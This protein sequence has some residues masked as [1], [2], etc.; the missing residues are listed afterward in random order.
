M[1]ITS[2][3][4]KTK[5][6][7]FWQQLLFFLSTSP[8]FGRLEWKFEPSMPSILRGEL[9]HEQSVKTFTN[10]FSDQDDENAI[11][12][13]LIKTIFRIPTN[14]QRPNP[15][16]IGTGNE[17]YTRTPEIDPQYNRYHINQQT[18]SNLLTDSQIQPEDIKM[19]QNKLR[20]LITPHVTEQVKEIRDFYR[21]KLKRVKEQ[22]SHWN[23]LIRTRN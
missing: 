23:Q 9:S 18:A 20:V 5:D 8:Y 7:K 4:L 12:R 2:Y 6:F 17:Y 15:V 16:W 19:F 22:L 13:S 1:K 3:Q 14:Y 11:I 10:S 21:T